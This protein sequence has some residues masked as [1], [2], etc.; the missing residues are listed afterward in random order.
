M[1]WGAGGPDPLKN[2]KAIGFLSNTGPQ[3]FVS[4]FNNSCFLRGERIQ[5]PLKVGH[6]PSASETKCLRTDEGPILLIFRSSLL[7]KINVVKM[8]DEVHL[9]CWLNIR[10]FAL[11]QSSKRQVSCSTTVSKQS[12]N[13]LHKCLQTIKQHAAL[14]SPNN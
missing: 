2:H 6:H 12:G 8:F 5:I 14:V 7:L 11:R 4:H 10:H 9:N 13:M 3:Y 1:G